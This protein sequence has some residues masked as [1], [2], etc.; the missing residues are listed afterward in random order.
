MVSPR[1]S[2]RTILLHIALRRHSRPVMT[3]ERAGHV[4]EPTNHT[5]PLWWPLQTTS[6]RAAGTACTAAGNQRSWQDGQRSGVS[7]SQIRLSRLVEDT[8]ATSNQTW[9]FAVITDW[10][11]TSYRHVSRPDE[12][13]ETFLLRPYLFKFGSSSA[14]RRFSKVARQRRLNFT[15]PFSGEKN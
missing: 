11:L 1:P 10:T 7:P 12:V 3:T 2:R 14:L 13:A 15:I 4:A 6:E 8:W 5:G 9:S